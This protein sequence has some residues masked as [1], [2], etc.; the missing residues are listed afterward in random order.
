MSQNQGDLVRYQIRVPEEL[1]QQ[2][3]AIAIGKGAKLHP[4]TK[5]PQLS[6]TIVELLQLALEQYDSTQEEQL[7]KETSPDLELIQ[8]QIADSQR[9]QSQQFNQL[10]NTLIE[11]QRQTQAEL[12]RLY[13][14]YYKLC[15]RVK[16][17]EET[18]EKIWDSY[19][20]PQQLMRPLESYSAGPWMVNR[21]WL[22]LNG[23]FKEEAFNEWNHGEVRQDQRG[24]FWRR[25]DM[26]NTTENF[27][28]PSNLAESQIFYV[29]AE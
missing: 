14:L 25:V 12:N 7:H 6:E 28:I 13:S 9:Q 18:P 24:N 17:E 20:S 5:R 15:D 8:N 23:C 21:Q 11:A 3:A 10:F 4:R 26:A 1:Y 2:L 27:Q 22:S 16:K 19:Q 29:L